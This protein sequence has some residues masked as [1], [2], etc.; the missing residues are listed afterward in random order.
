M[1]V[2]DLPYRWRNVS[3]ALVAFGALLVGWGLI[4][5]VAPGP[6][7]AGSVYNLDPSTGDGEV[8]I[9]E[10]Y[11]SAIRIYRGDQAVLCYGVANAREVWLEP[12]VDAIKPS[13]MRCL[14]VTPKA[15]TTYTL[16]VKGADGKQLSRSVKVDVGPPPPKFV[17]LATSGKEVARGEKL[18]ICYGVKNA[19]SL[20]LEPAGTSLPPSE[21]NCIELRPAASAEY[22]LT[23][24][25]PEG[26]TAQE[27]FQVKVR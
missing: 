10:F 5:H 16:W 8:R 20:R 13:V 2:L 25:S 6:T 1:S 4:V 19:A 11:T 23:A 18:T 26:V 7:Q 27:Q 3:W 9:N 12:A 24:T 17:L 22:R 14:P 21:K 15:S